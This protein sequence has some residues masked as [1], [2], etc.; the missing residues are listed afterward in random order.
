MDNSGNNGR[1]FYMRKYET[2]G[3]IAHNQS[4][5]P[6]RARSGSMGQMDELGNRTNRLHF[7]AITGQQTL[8]TSR[9]DA[10]PHGKSERK[11]EIVYSTRPMTIPGAIHKD[12]H[13]GVTR[14]Y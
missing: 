6:G 12:V 7:H 4:G 3:D 9:P 1:V 14:K 13:E 2:G 8:I 5:S 10:G 11:H